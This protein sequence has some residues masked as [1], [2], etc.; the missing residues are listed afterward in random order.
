MEIVVF[1]EQTYIMLSQQKLSIIL[2]TE[3]SENCS[4]KSMSAA[5]LIF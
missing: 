5:K 2:E 1:C 4:Y 3:M